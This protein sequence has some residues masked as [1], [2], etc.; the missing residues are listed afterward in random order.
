M[1]IIQKNTYYQKLKNKQM[2]KTILGIFAA[3]CMLF[4][5]STASY[6]QG[7]KKVARTVKAKTVDASRGS[8]TNIKSEAPTTDVA[9]S[10]ARGAGSCNI[11]F[12]NYTGYYVNIYVDGYYRGQLSPW[13]GG[14]VVVG[15]GYTS[16]YCITAGKTLEWSDAGNC[17]GSYTFKLYP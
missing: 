5:A 7:P 13:G 9:E 14:T 15:D 16:I 8:N 10:K 3:V 6:A 11:Y 4:A 1:Q 2:K 12:S 17:F